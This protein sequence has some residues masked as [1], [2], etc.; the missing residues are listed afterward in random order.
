MDLK[1]NVLF[2]GGIIMKSL[3]ELLYTNGR[4]DVDPLSPTKCYC[5]G[6]LSKRSDLIHKERSMFPPSTICRKSREIY[7]EFFEDCEDPLE[8][9]DLMVK[10][11]GE[12]KASEIQLEVHIS[13]N[14]DHT[15][16]CIDCAILHDEA[17]HEK[18]NARSSEEGSA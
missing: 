15:Y 3:F 14:I 16:E 17:Y 1:H 2:K 11:L 13:T 5:C 7:D 8:A 18:L 12:E 9:S 10:K 4:C 6:K